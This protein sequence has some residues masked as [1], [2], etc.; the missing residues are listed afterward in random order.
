MYTHIHTHVH[1]QTHAH[2]SHV[3]WDQAAGVHVA[4]EHVSEAEL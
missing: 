2:T 3:P 1:T 4:Q